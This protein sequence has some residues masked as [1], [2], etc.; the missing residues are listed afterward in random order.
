[1][2]VAVAISGATLTSAAATAVKTAVAVASFPDE[3]SAE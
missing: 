2:I 3:S 1:M